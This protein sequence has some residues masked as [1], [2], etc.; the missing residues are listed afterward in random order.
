MK[1]EELKE[2]IRNISEPRRTGYGNI[3]HKLEDIIII[4]LCT[5]ICGGEDFADMEAFG[6][7]R[8]EY[9]SKFLYF[10]MVYLIVT[11]SDEYLK[12]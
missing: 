9:L 3:R 1:I 12:N 11:H 6:K 4:G 10:R 7:S 2:G 5:I 8:Q